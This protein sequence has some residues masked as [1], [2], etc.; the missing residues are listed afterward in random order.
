MAAIILVYGGGCHD[1]GKWSNYV[2]TGRRLGTT[3]TAIITPPHNSIVHT[4][5]AKVLLIEAEYVILTLLFIL[6]TEPQT[7]EI[8]HIMVICSNKPGDMKKAVILRV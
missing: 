4:P 6:T 2:W 7:L 8:L 3:T 1:K 5:V